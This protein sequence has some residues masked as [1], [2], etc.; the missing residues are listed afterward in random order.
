MTMHAATVDAYIAVAC[1]IPVRHKFLRVKQ[2]FQANQTIAIPDG[3]VVITFLTSHLSFVCKDLIPIEPGFLVA[4]VN[5]ERP[6]RN[7]LGIFLGTPGSLH[8][9][10]LQVH[11][12]HQYIVLSSVLS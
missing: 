2:Q 7:A 12:S 9:V 10:A 6:F 11:S 8:S 5:C 4:Q 3:G 1:I